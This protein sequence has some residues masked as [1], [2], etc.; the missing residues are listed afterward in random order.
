MYTID[1]KPLT[2]TDVIG[3]DMPKKV[4][5]AAI[6]KPDTSPKTFLFKGAWGTGK[7]AL[8]TIFGKAINCVGAKKPCG[9]CKYCKNSY[10]YQELDSSMMGNAQSVRQLRESWYYSLG[11]VYKVIVIDE[12]QVASSAAQAAFL[13]VLENPPEKT[14]FLLLTTNPEKV[15][16]PI[17]SRSMELS[18]NL[19]KPYELAQVVDRVLKIEKQNIETETRDVIYRRSGGHARDAI[20][21]LEMA[22]MVGEPA[23]LKTIQLN[24][25]LLKKIFGAFINGK[26]SVAA[27]LIKDLI[28][29]PVSYL[30]V[31]LENFF[32]LLAE[33][34]LGE[35]NSLY[36]GKLDAKVYM[37]ALSHYIRIKPLLRGSTSDFYTAMMGFSFPL[38]PSVSISSS[39]QSQSRF[40]KTK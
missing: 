39:Q 33:K 32:A 19:L 36:R 12:I 27:S 35:N 6:S 3:Q 18:F 14:F 17:I 5:L 24:D 37:K 26:T 16:S 9:I 23:F 21:L 38:S 34:I 10:S 20:M 31:D 25:K 22:L 11:D 7:T 8:A 13:K 15:L 28:K 40:M 4:L 1:H 29:S 30:S 2:F